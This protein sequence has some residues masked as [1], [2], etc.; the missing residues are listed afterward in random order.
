MASKRG[1]PRVKGPLRPLS[2][3]HR[4]DAHPGCRRDTQHIP[5]P[6]PGLLRAVTS[7]SASP[8]I[9]AGFV[10]PFTQGLRCTKPAGNLTD[11]GLLV[12]FPAFPASSFASA[13]SEEL[14]TE[15]GHWCCQRETKSSALNYGHE[16]LGLQPVVH[17][18]LCLMHLPKMSFFG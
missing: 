8:K 9:L 18:S 6:T 3:A 11:M 16:H 14:L 7:L 12:T 17:F 15:L 1:V 2:W 4:I 13:K 5:E 10:C